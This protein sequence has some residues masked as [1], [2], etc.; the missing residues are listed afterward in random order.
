MMDRDDGHRGPST[1]G[2]NGEAGTP[3]GGDPLVREIL[4]GKKGSIRQAPLPKGSPSWEEVLDLP[5]SE[6]ERRASSDETGYRTIRKLLK[7]KRF[8]R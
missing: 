7:D 6:I 3:K 4:R 1:T 2:G 5:L 8:D